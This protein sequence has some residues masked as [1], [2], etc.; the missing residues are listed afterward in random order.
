MGD[1]AKGRIS[2]LLEKQRKR[3]EDELLRRA[4][5]GTAGAGDSAGAGVADPAR[6]RRALEDSQKRA[7]RDLLEGIFGRP[8]PDTTRR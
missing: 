6:D 2:D 1:R 8:K 4:G 3:L 5:G 7:A